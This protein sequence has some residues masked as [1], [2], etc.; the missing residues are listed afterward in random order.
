MVAVS[1]LGT[2]IV[3]CERVGGSGVMVTHDR[4]GNHCPGRLWWERR[5]C[6]ERR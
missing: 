1:E 4:D 2:R 6:P 3:M 5:G